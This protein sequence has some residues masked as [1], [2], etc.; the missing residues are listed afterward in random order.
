MMTLRKEDDD[1]TQ[2][3]NI[4]I[5]NSLSQDT[6]RYPCFKP[7]IVSQA[8]KDLYTRNIQNFQKFEKFKFNPN[9]TNIT[10]AHYGTPAI[11]LYFH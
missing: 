2:D 4:L 11:V 6:V 7:E 1:T 3:I 10:I 5:T 9:I 8:H